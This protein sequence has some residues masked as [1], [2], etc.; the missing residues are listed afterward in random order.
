[1]FFMLIESN[2]NLNVPPEL[3]QY[4]VLGSRIA[5]LAQAKRQQQRSSHI[6]YEAKY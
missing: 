4:E 5:V 1:M 3:S 6:A 2:V